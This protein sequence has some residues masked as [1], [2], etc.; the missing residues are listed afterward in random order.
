MPNNCNPL[1]NPSMY[2]LSQSQYQQCS[3]GVKSE[4]LKWKA[5]FEAVHA[6]GRVQLQYNGGRDKVR[7]YDLAR[8][9][10][11]ASGTFYCKRKALGGKWF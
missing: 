7:E 6:Y 4:S 5:T 2:G 8:K 9:M 10:G 1:K 11:G 3:V